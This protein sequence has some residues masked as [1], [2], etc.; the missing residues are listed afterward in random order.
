MSRAEFDSILQERKNRRQGPVS[1]AP[2]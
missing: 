1:G 2:K